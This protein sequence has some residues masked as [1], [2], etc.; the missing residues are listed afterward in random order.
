MRAWFKIIGL[1]F[2]VFAILTISGCEDETTTSKERKF[3][4]EQLDKLN[5]SKSFDYKRS[6]VR[7]TNPL[8]GWLGDFFKFM[9]KAFGGYLAY[10]FLGVL[11]LVILILILK[12]KPAAATKIIG[13]K[14]SKSKT[15]VFDEE[16][17]KHFDK[18]EL[19]SK[20]QSALKGR[21][22]ASA[23]RY[24]FLLLLLNLNENKQLQYSIEKTNNEYLIELNQTKQVPFEMLIRIYDFVWYGK[25]PATNQVWQLFNKHLKQLEAKA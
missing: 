3:N 4:Q 11:I 21:D 24:S 10:V 8:W 25:Y 5:Q 19:E 17:G 18:N 1:V 22:F 23:I 7:K 16:E 13:K 9:S 2:L 15:V 20:I 12:I 6:Y 14:E